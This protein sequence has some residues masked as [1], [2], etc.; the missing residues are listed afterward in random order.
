MSRVIAALRELVALFVDDGSLALAILAWVAVVGLVLPALG[1]AETLRALLLFAGCALV[2]IENTVR[3]SR[4]GHG[5][6]PRPGGGIE[7][8]P[9]GD[10]G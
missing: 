10:V 9:A 1:I 5:T 4:R 2:L 3:S 7:I 6:D 8:P